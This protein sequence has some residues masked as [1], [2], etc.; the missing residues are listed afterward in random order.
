M[1]SLK[2]QGWSKYL[3]LAG[4][5]GAI[6]APDSRLASATLGALAS[7]AFLLRRD[8]PGG[9]ALYHSGTSE[10]Y[11]L[12]LGADLPQLLENEQSER[13]DALEAAILSARSCGGPILAT[14]ATMALSILKAKKSL[15]DW[16]LGLDS[17][18]VCRC[19]SHSLPRFHERR[20][21]EA[22]ALAVPERRVDLAEWAEI[23]K[24]IG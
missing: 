7:G 21:G 22:S 13:A 10:G 14:R 12:G 6:W 17:S 19:L 8:E 16:V 4:G 9:G 11:L 20:I 3:I 1:K 23:A 18:G 24:Q 15:G 5:D 2:E